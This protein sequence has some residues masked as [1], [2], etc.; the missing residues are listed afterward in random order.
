MQAG[1]IGLEGFSL[2]VRQKPERQGQRV[3]S[4]DANDADAAVALRRRD[5]G[6]RF[7]FAEIH[8]W[9]LDR[10]NKIFRIYGIG[11]EGLMDSR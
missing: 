2:R 11:V 7:G 5:G 10:I 8:S 6:Y 4:A 9:E 1:V 3:R